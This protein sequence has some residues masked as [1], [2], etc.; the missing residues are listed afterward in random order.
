[1]TTAAER[2][3]TYAELE[4]ALPQLRAAPRE[5]GVLEMIVRRPVSNEREVL[6]A[7]EL[8]TGAGLVGDRW[9]P[10]SHGEPLTLISSRLMALLARSRDRWPLAGDQLYV[11]FDLSAEHVPPG[12]RLS[13]GG[14]VIEVSAEPHTPCRKFRD[15]YGTD[16]LRFV[17]SPVGQELNLRGI[18]AH[19]LT[20][21]AVRVGDAICA[22]FD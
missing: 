18:N 7:A 14:A 8:Q 10:A 16:A 5:R 6:E 1:V 15:R 20:G 13:I 9:T 4:A 3:A 22:L 2:F 11:D 17:A 12:T 19:V 21:G